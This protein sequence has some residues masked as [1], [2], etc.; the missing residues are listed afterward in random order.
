MTESKKGGRKPVM[1]RFLDRYELTMKIAEQEFKD[2]GVG[3]HEVIRV[4][5]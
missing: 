2:S 1:F 5:P 4:N 3:I